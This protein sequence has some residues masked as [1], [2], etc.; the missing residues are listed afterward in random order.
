M[1]SPITAAVH[2]WDVS[3][4]V[5]GPGTRFVLFLAGCPLRC[6][7]CQNPDSWHM[8]DGRRMTLD[9]ILHEVQ[10]YRRFLRVA[11]GGVTVSGGE[12]LLQSAVHHPVLPPGPRMVALHRAGHVRCPGRPADDELL[13]VTDL[14]LLDIKSFDP[15]TYKRLTGAP[16]APTLDFARRLAAVGKAMWIRFVLVPDLTD[17]PL[18][19][20][21]LA[22]F[23]AGWVRRCSGWRSCRSTG[24]GYP[25]TRPSGGRSRSTPRRRR[26][27]RW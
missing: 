19:V 1:T 6:Q 10:P 15:L 2:S 3:T 22:D 20:A 26:A 4:G 24:S 27:R 9:E 23:V 25:S 16:V 21:G 11:H 12:P 14:V 17:D 18:N 8:R 5:D 13:A 7:Y